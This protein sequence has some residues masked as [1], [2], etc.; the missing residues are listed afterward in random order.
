MILSAAMMLDWLGRRRGLEACTVA[1]RRIE[2]A[3]ERAYASG[4]IRPVEL[5]GTSGTRAIGRAV[6]DAID[7]LG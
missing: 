3:V 2:T 4:R 6:A 7:E 1:A 5:G